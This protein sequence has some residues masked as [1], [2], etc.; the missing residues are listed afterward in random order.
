MKRSDYENYKWYPVTDEAYW[1]DDD[2]EEFPNC[3]TIVRDTSAVIYYS[4]KPSILTMNHCY[5]GWGTMAKSPE[6]YSFMIIET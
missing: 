2:E 3:Q 5:L 1:V 4:E 6:Y